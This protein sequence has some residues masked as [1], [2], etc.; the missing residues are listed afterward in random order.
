MGKVFFHV[1]LDAFFA[2]VEQLEHPEWRGKPVIVGGKPG[3]PRSVVSTASYEARK[4]GVHSAMPSATAYRL[5][6]QGIFVHGNMSL[7]HEKSVQVMSIF[8]GYSP[9]VQQMSIDEAFID[10]TGTSRLFGSPEETALKLKKEVKEKT[11][12]TVS[13]GIAPTKYLAKIASEMN[14]PDGL[15]VIK[16]GEEESFMLSLPLEKVWGIGDKTL[17]RLNSLQ[18][19]TTKDVYSR[20][21]QML[22]NL[23]GRAT[24]TFLYNA[25]RGME[26]E[27]FNTVPKSHSLSAETTYETDL[28]YQEQ[29]E[30][31]LLELCQ[32][33]V[34]RMLREKIRSRTVF[35]KIRYDDFTTVTAQ[36]TFSTYVSSTGDFYEKILSI[37]KKKYNN[38]QGIRLLGAG[39]QNTE[40]QDSPVQNE[41]FDFGEEKKQKLEKAILNARQKN[42]DLKITRARL[43]KK[44]MILAG[45]STLFFPA[46]LHSQTV[47]ET[48]HTSDGAGAIVFDSRKVSPVI[49]PDSS[50]LFNYS[51]NDS[52]IEFLASGYWQTLFTYTAGMSTGFGTTSAVTTSAP[53]FSQNVDLSLWVLINKHWY[54]ESAFADSFD[55]NTVAAGYF[56]DGLVKNARIAN[57]NITF[58]DIYSVSDIQKGIGGGDNEAPG[59]M[60]SL[61]T[62]RFYSDTALRYDMLAS[63][64][65]TWYGKNA[66][67][68]TDYELTSYLTGFRYCLPE[69]CAGQITGVYVES[70]SG[71]V[72]ETGTKRKKIRYTKLDSSRYMVSVTANSLYLSQEARAKAKNGKLP[73]VVIT[74]RSMPSLTDFENEIETFFKLDSDWKEKYS[75]EY[76]LT[77]FDGNAYALMIQSSEGFS[78]FMCC[79]LYD[80]GLNQAADAQIA[81]K[82]TEIADTT[83]LAQSEEIDVSFVSEDFINTKHN[84]VKLYLNDSSS[85]ISSVQER[86]PLAATNPGIY[87]GYGSSDDS[88]LK[89]RTY[90]SVSRYDIGT[91]AVPGTVRVWKNGILDPLAT[92][93]RESGCITLSGTVSSTDKIHAVWYEDNS[94]SMTSSIAFASGAGYIINE[95][96]KADISLA[97]RWNYSPEKDFST[98]SYTSP[99]SVTL[100]SKLQYENENFSAR[101]IV[102]S[103]FDTADTTGLYRILSMNE[104][105]S[106]TYY[107]SKNSAYELPSGIIPELTGFDSVS[108][109]EENNFSQDAEEG[110]V[111]S[112]FSGYAIPLNWN[113]TSTA[114]E[115]SP[116]WAAVSVA[117]PSNSS[118]LKNASV[119]ELAFKNIS[120]LLND[121][122]YKVYLQLGV[123]AEDD[124]K[125][126][127]SGI[128][129]WL[130][131]SE[132]LISSSDG[133]ETVKVIITDEQKA[134]ISSYHDARIIVTSPSSVS[135]RILTGPY[136][137]TGSAFSVKSENLTVSSSQET[138]SS[139]HNSLIK[140]LNS[141]T[142]YVQAFEWKNPLSTEE[143]ITISRWFNEIDVNQYK[144]LSLFIA[145]T[146]VSELTF[147]LLDGNGKKSV[148]VNLSEE[149]LN[150]LKTSG[151]LQ[152]EKYNKLSISLE[153]KTA[154]FAGR[155]I[156]ASVNTKIIPSRIIITVRTTYS[157]KLKIDELILEDSK[158]SI[159]LG[160]QF[161][162]SYSTKNDFFDELSAKTTATASSSAVSGDFSDS[163]SS[164]INQSAVSIR[165][166]GIRFCLDAALSSS[167]TVVPQASHVFESYSPLLNLISFSESY[168]FDHEEGS[169]Q[170]SNSLGLDLKDFN[171]PLTLNFSAG[172][173]SDTGTVS[174]NTSSELSFVTKP[175]SSKTALTVSQQINANSS[176]DAQCETDTYFSSWK[177]ITSM[178]FSSGEKNAYRRKL[179]FKQNFSFSLPY[180]ELTPKINFET[181]E[182]YK[183][184]TSAAYTDKTQLALIFPFKIRSNLFSLS[185]KKTAG[186]KKTASVNGTYSSDFDALTDNFNEKDWYYTAAP[187]ADLISSSLPGDVLSSALKNQTASYTGAYSLSWRRNFYG[188]KYDFFIPSDVSFSFTRDI[189][190]SGTC[191]DIHQAGSSISYSAVNIFG[192]KGSLRLLKC[193]EQ[194]E[195]TSSLE[196][197]AKIPR[198]SPSDFTIQISG[199]FQGTFY[200]KDQDTIKF[201]LEGT[202]S[203]DD[204]WS[205]KSTMLYKRQAYSSP[206]SSIVQLFSPEWKRQG[207]KLTRSDSLNISLSE[208]EYYKKQ[209]ISYLH[210]FDMTVSKYI[211]LNTDIS[212]GYQCT[213]D[214]IIYLNAGITVGATINF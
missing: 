134:H 203:Q 171:V 91:R 69:G 120:T 185:W 72:I 29:F 70:S 75:Y 186:G 35:L 79:E 53:V 110:T 31:A 44:L 124:F 115:S 210:E 178:E 164:L 189:S 207:K 130:L 201:A 180:A 122:D 137:C 175:F 52:D 30:T 156:K 194:D 28:Y 38:Q 64:E 61:A 132:N 190:A 114:T 193:F 177:E 131:T 42:P 40:S 13:V 54:F 49:D 212:L 78:P 214:K 181:A 98:A 147:T 123:Q 16:E 140:K 63:A 198:N 73:K 116:N 172:A 17:A 128:P 174:Q 118:A 14:K 163:E 159:T 188:N 19:F 166:K 15:Y 161:T 4:Y 58:P 55:K 184:S 144:T 187:V 106:Q 117:M 86:F 208:D 103:S 24:G 196:A 213:W 127:D 23:M 160:D 150:E 93:S 125:Y 87:L 59:I 126:E 139:L 27:S 50:S 204:S 47:S 2:S 165:T 76:E 56:G 154:F 67:S 60:V 89:V 18:I 158:T 62:D 205:F 170:K 46:K 1:D 21:L 182:E 66:V 121:S 135:G 100:A 94:L 141:G 9:D 45:L 146:E 179:G 162:A 97:A 10:M 129:T 152:D 133:R 51:I 65:K 84:Y 142:N 199:Y 80:T 148:E 81:S 77:D 88:V 108:L 200:I 206:V 43:L 202:Y 155:K 48:Q 195:Y 95:N 101:N 176:P 83:Y 3:E 191:T 105:D 119:F 169:L 104:E 32:T 153:E 25:V 113:F 57:R 85:Q 209:N 82:T 157:G 151:K 149:L 173:S 92:Y 41:L 109:E 168:S 71:S 68:S 197:A 183:N 111:V 36:E 99:G 20:S 74:L 112:D 11:G 96:T 34:F 136:R 6:P 12:L 22:Q 37:F 90:T 39:L 138:D 33:L 143:S 7:Y 145:Q 192:R 211:T 167:E 102:S 107:L 5:C 26:D 8:A